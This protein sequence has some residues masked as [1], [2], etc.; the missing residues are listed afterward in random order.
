MSA[1]NVGKRVRKRKL[2]VQLRAHR[3]GARCNIQLLCNRVHS[4]EHRVAPGALE[5]KEYVALARVVLVLSFSRSHACE[6]A[7][8]RRRESERILQT[9]ARTGSRRATKTARAK[10]VACIFHFSICASVSVSPREI[11]FER[12]MFLL[13]HPFSFFLI[14]KRIVS[15]YIHGTA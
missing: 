14:Q 5:R 4:W 2:D 1:V 6:R 9:C 3:A 11:F 12:K 15:S 10:P 7:S 13:D 8:G